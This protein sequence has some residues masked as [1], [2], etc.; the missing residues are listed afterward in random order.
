M[1]LRHVHFAPCDRDQGFTLIELIVVMAMI[2]LIAA[3]ATPDFHRAMP[4]MELR[5]SLD[6]LAAELRRT[7]ASALRDGAPRALTIDLAEASY[8]NASG[9]RIAL[10]E[11]V[12]ISVTTGQAELNAANNTARILFFPDGTAVGADIRLTRTDE[13]HRIHVDWLTGR[14][15]LNETP[16]AGVKVTGRPR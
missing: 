14:V 10:P 4:G 13:K 16:Q 3:L 15:R 9:R 1:M 12:E 8:R 5:S 2:G 11:Q 7:R 6:T